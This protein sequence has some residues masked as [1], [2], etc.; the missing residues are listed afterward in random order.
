ME[1]FAVKPSISFLCLYWCVLL[2]LSTNPSVASPVFVGSN[3]CE[4]CH[5]DEYKHWQD[6]DHFH[7]MAVAS[8]ESVMGNFDNVS[9]SHFGVNTTFFRK[10]DK[11]FV[12]T[13]NAKG[14]LQDFEISFTFGRYPLQQYL[15]VFDDGRYQALGIAWDSRSKKE[16]GQ[17][18]FHLYPDEAIA[19]DDGLHWTGAFQNWNSRCAFCHST[20]LI[21][22]YNQMTNSYQTQYSEINVGCE[23]CHGP[24][25]DHLVWATD[26]QKPVTIG[27]FRGFT[28]SLADEGVWS[29]PSA[30]N[31][32]TQTTLK[33]EGIA[34]P[35]TQIETCALC[36][37]RRQLLDEAPHGKRFSD[38][39][40]L[41]LLEEG[42]YFA[43]GQIQGEVYV[44]GSF[45][46]SKMHAEGV[47]CSNCHEPH[48]LKLKHEGNDL[49]LQ[50]HAQQTFDR[51]EHHHHATDTV[52][53]QCINCHMPERTY[54]VIDPRR[55]HGFRIPDP[56]LAL[57]LST[58][59]V[60]SGCHTDKSAQWTIDN[61]QNW[62]GETASTPDSQAILFDLARKNDSSAVGGLRKIASDST[63]PAIVKAFAMQ[64]LGR[65]P[66]GR[67]PDGRFPDNQNFQ[68][69][70]QTL[71]SAD[72]LERLGAIRGLEWLP[73]AD[74]LHLLLPL[75]KDRSKMVRMT[76][77]AQLAD[78][79]LQRL[80][81]KTH[82][83]IQMLFNEYVTTSQLDADMP[84]N[85]L[86]L[87]IFYTNRGMFK[88][89]EK[90]YQH[91]LILSPQFAPAML[92]LADL[93]RRQGQDDIAKRLFLKVISVAPQQAAA[94]HALGLLHVRQ[95]DMLKA[96]KHLRQ[97]Y[98]LAPHQI[99]YA[100][101]YS[102]AL[103]N[104]QQIEDAIFVAESALKKQP[105]NRELLSA[106]LSYYRQKGDLV[107]YNKTRAVLNNQKP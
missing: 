65:F 12:T 10:A 104:V 92:N 9:F 55:D 37:S 22:N 7:G 85:Q 39:A 63:V 105:G 83:G 89:A 50:C 32:K 34:Q 2:L 43:D 101:V 21:K 71:K 41:S 61:M 66:D 100:Y 56:K 24:A 93:Y 69:L 72:P 28:I 58:P 45:L 49:C 38:V 60:C 102:V 16:G 19:H 78:A 103:Q 91:A 17:R 8:D 27:G 23:S 36:H 3:A 80:N 76:V 11:F 42:L 73:P 5:T 95:K 31:K 54:M 29:S 64:E 48:G 44:Y 86:N 20:N 82:A 84:G 14:D 4:T 1:G 94:H 47:V 75:I 51:V 62:Y 99:R 35:V 26:Q 88:E 87:G 90:A 70:T 30:P 96:L 52:G 46:Q 57:D 33:R 107:N 13:D 67:F 59:D 74:R 25:S 18:W 77:A 53:A 68:L 106:L 98:Q 81:K 6:S 40:M 97:A 79:P 15:V